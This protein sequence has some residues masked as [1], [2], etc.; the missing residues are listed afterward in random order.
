[1]GFL[2]N[3]DVIILAGSLCTGT[4]ETVTSGG[5][6][7]GA[8]CCFPFKYGSTSYSECIKTANR[9]EPDIPWCPVADEYKTGVEWGYCRLTRQGTNNNVFFSKL[10]F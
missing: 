1:M 10:Q 6:A 9:S 2:I 3:Y 8:K 5:T 4:R 7:N